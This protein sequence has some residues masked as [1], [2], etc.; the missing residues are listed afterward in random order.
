MNKIAIVVPAHIPLSQDWINALKR[1]ADIGHADVIIVDDSDGKLNVPDMPEFLIM[2]YS[3]QRDLLGEL[4]EDFAKLFHKSSACRV[5]GHIWAYVS[6]Y[7]IVIG[8]D[9]D[10]I[11]PFHFVED[12]IGTLNTTRNNGWINPL[13]GSGLYPRGFPY[14]MRNWRTV[15]N[16]GM[17]ENVLDLNGK[18]RSP[19]EPKRINAG[20]WNAPAPIPFSG[21]NF[22]LTR[23]VLFGFLFL[24]NFE[25]VE[26]PAVIDGSSMNFRWQFRRIDDI[27]GGYIFQKLLHKLHLG[28]TYGQP[29]VYHDTVVIKEEDVAEEEAMYRFEDEFIYQVDQVLGNAIHYMK[30]KN[31][32][33]SMIEFCSS[34][35]RH[36]MVLDNPNY[37]FKELVP[38]F[39]WWAKV[40]N[41]YG[42]K[43]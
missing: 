10:C 12:N 33:E 19:N 5:F 37:K 24:P 23:D 8:L 39:E 9:S 38:A 21:M 16:M 28:V 34:F 13:S 3:A 2:G 32:N 27:W 18:D 42:D 7:D 17:W 26:R 6:G 30:D 25:Y 35:I 22:A 11:V 14:S 4:Y 43:V 20:K 1:E 31:L 36:D 40:I 29:I 15:A 41:K